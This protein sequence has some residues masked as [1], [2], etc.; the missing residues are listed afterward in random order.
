[1]LPVDFGFRYGDANI[2]WQLPRLLKSRARQTGERHRE[3]R[4]SV[5]VSRLPLMHCAAH[6][7]RKHYSWQHRS[8]ASHAHTIVSFHGFYYRSSV[9]ARMA[10]FLCSILQ[11]LSVP[12]QRMCCHDC[13]NP[14]TKEL[15]QWGRELQENNRLFCRKAQMQ[16]FRLTFRGNRYRIFC[17]EQVQLRSRC[18]FEIHIRQLILFEYLDGCRF[19]H[20]RLGLRLRPWFWAAARLIVGRLSITVRVPWLHCRK[21]ICPTSR[22]HDDEFS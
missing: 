1:M 5:D 10:Q 19:R 7:C 20:L 8:F 12:K 13:R 15:L 21:H 14:Y 17:K 11:G 6:R 2:C 3:H 4:S 22:D 16:I 18:L 9:L